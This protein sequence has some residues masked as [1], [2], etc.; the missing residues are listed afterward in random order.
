MKEIFI[1]GLDMRRDYYLITVARG[2]TFLVNIEQ[3][4]NSDFVIVW[5]AGS[6][7]SSIAPFLKIKSEIKRSQDP[8]VWRNFIIKRLQV[9]ISHLKARDNFMAAPVELLGNKLEWTMS[10]LSPIKQRGKRSAA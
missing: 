4:A 3:E 1:S 5:T 9:T 2:P 8:T 7:I 6:Q 10:S